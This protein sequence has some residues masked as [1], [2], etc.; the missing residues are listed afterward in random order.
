MNGRKEHEQVTEKR[1]QRLIS[2]APELI[3]N[4]SYSFD[5]KTE[6]TKEV[7]I[8]YILGF[9]EYFDGVDITKL[10]KSDINKYMDSVKFHEVNGE[11]KENGVSIR[12]ARLAAIKHF[13]NYLVDD[14]VI[15]M[16][17]ALSIRPPKII[18]EKE[19]VALTPVE[20]KRVRRNIIYGTGT[21]RSNNRRKKWINRDLCLVDIGF[22]TGLRCSAI[23]EIDIEDID[24][25][26]NSIK[27]V[28]KG[29][30]VKNVFIGERAKESIY[31]WLQ[32]RKDIV[33]DSNGP[34]F[35]SSRKQ[36]LSVREI[37]EIIKRNT[38]NIDKHI[39]PHKMRSTCATNL[40]EKTNDIYLVQ[41]VLGHK[42]IANTRRYA[43]MSEEKK[44]N[45]ADIMD[46]LI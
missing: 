24:F 37:A 7:Y 33:G 12:N 27:V 35:I 16:N 40:Y 25:E 29:N 2:N 18:E 1:I 6:K 32:N 20:I 28:E 43:R 19:V 10:K 41:E 13:Y 44:K 9:F 17:P 23:S 21:E 34:L 38:I 11:I 36:R 15:E 14:G 30:R 42:N 5:D 8:R 39:T 26:N 4:Y 45:A 46:K 31:N 22:T 3:K